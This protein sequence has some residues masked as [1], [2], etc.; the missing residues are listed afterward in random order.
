MRNAVSALI[1]AAFLGACAPVWETAVR[2]YQVGR[3]NEAE[4]SL[5]YFAKNGEPGRQAE[6]K[7]LLAALEEEQDRAIKFLLAEARHARRRAQADDESY[8]VSAAYLAASLKLMAADDPRRGPTEKLQTEVKD[9]RAKRVERYRADLAAFG[10]E[11]QS[12]KRCQGAKWIQRVRRLSRARDLSGVNAGTGDLVT[13]A[14]V[15]AERCFELRA[16]ES[17]VALSELADVVWDLRSPGAPE[18]ARLSAVARARIST[19]APEVARNE[20]E[21]LSE[22]DVEELGKEPIEV[23]AA[24]SRK[25]RRPR[26]ARASTATVSAER[27]DDERNGPSRRDLESRFNTLYEAGNKFAAFTAL[28]A[29]IR[30]YPDR[31]WLRSLKRRHQTD[32]RG[33]IDQYLSDGEAALQREQPDRAFEFYS[34]VLVLEPGNDVAQDRKQKIENLRALKRKRGRE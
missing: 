22:N 4:A 19:R 25:R 17:A 10:V 32:R 6:A 8:R 18:Y 9:L 16:Y 2:D 33:L 30:N 11:V 27:T 1:I 12:A 23:A 31:Q 5:R 28:D 15:A 14:T 26:I 20:A 21:D 3:Y 24:S 7:R 29:M 34:K 13:F